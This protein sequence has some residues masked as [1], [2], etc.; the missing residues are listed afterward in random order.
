MNKILLILLFPITLFSQELPIDFSN[1]LHQFEAINVEFNLITDPTDSANDV[2]EIISS[3]RNVDVFELILTTFID[4]TDVSNNSISFDYYATQSGARNISL[5][6]DDEQYGE[7]PI[8]VGFTTSGVI[9][10]ETI[11]FDF[12]NAYHP[13]PNSSTPV[14]L[15][16]YGK[17]VLSFY[18]WVGSPNNPIVEN[19]YYIDNITGAQNGG[20][21][22]ILYGDAILTTQQEVY[23]FGALSYSKVV[24]SVK[25][26]P[27][28]NENSTDITDLSPLNSINSVGDFTT[29]FLGTFINETSFEI[30]DNHNLVNL[31]GLNRLKTV[32]N[33][34]IEDNGNLVSLGLNSL[35]KTS[36]LTIKNNVLLNTVSSLGN[37]NSIG[38]LTI[39]NNNSLTS[40]NGL[41]SLQTVTKLYKLNILNNDNLLSISNIST[42]GANM[43][44]LIIENNQSL[45]SISNID[46]T[47]SENSWKHSG[48]EN[49]TI[50]DNVNLTSLSNIS[51]FTLAFK[52]SARS[53]TLVIDNNGFSDLS[54]LENIEHA[55][56]FVSD[57]V[58]KNN[59]NLLSLNGLNFPTQ[60]SLSK[61]SYVPSIELGNNNLLSDISALSNLSYVYH[62]KFKDNPSLTNLN[63]LRPIIECKKL[64]IE[65]SNGFTNLSGLENINLDSELFFLNTNLTDISQLGLSDDLYI[66]RVEENQGITDLSVFSVV[67]SMYRSATGT[68]NII[69]N[70][71]LTSLNGLENLHDPF[72]G[73]IKIQ[74]NDILNDFCAFTNLF[75]IG[76]F[77]SSSTLSVFGNEYNPNQ[78]NIADASSCSTLSVND[79]DIENINIFPNPTTDFININSDEITIKAE[80]YNLQG[81]EFNTIFLG[82]LIDIRSLSNGIYFLKLTTKKGNKIFKLLKK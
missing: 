23:D 12:D 1:S 51:K 7:L 62:L 57:I 4:V 42:G 9:G 20:S 43:S 35:E 68:L 28:A 5:L 76:T 46:F 48:V 25:I 54:G 3:D 66:I 70:S 58:I 8:H 41:G 22:N 36:S 33:L 19:M 24:G 80:L 73:H 44:Y 34:I 31:N 69:N 74:N 67:E 72:H 59:N 75:T 29:N 2:A 16:K 30:I 6:L 52:T 21:Y 47:H 14:I 26:I 18:N 32:R 39:D 17:I 50:K 56:F 77:T 38:S 10:W 65:G 64:T 82:N 40:I 49:F 60:P 27:P 11:T 37:L 61:Y 81:V 55:N 63:A 79:F 13:F 15:S 45:Q 53:Q 78:Q 71:Q